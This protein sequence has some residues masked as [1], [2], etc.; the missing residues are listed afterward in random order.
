[1]RI[2]LSAPSVSTDDIDIFNKYGVKHRLIAFPLLPV[3]SGEKKIKIADEVERARKAKGNGETL[4]YDSGVA[5]LWIKFYKNTKT[6]MEK[7][8]VGYALSLRRLFYTADVY[9]D[10]LRALT[11]EN[12]IDH[13][14]ELDIDH[15]VGMAPVLKIRDKLR[16]ATDKLI[17]VWRVTQ[18]QAEYETVTREFNYVG[19]SLSRAGKSKDYVG[20]L[21][22]DA[23]R[24]NVKVHVFAYV[25]PAFLYKYPCFSTDSSSWSKGRRWGIVSYL[26]NRT[27]E[28]VGGRPAQDGEQTFKDSSF[29]GATRDKAFNP[30][31]NKWALEA[32]VQEYI[33]LEENLTQVW[34]KRGY[35]YDR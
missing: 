9:A 4:M 2:Y 14:L 7:K 11:E 21:L 22:F 26:S 20:E 17:G 28:W 19:F 25:K 8:N 1:M 5:T 15:F 31:D 27:G 10:V 29:L 13:A 6:L 32:T 23:F 18:G 3:L 33:R 12:V 34:E 16:Q 35:V 30:V 24:R